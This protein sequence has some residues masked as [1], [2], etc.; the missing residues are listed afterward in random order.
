MKDSE[1]P[2]VVSPT[3]EPMTSSIVGE[4]SQPYAGPDPETA[5]DTETDEFIDYETLPFNEIDAI[6][7]LME[8]VQI[9]SQSTN[10]PLPPIEESELS[11]P[12]CNNPFVQKYDIPNAIMK[13]LPIKENLNKPI[14]R[15]DIGR[16]SAEHN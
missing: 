9:S 3:P 14:F 4:N 2:E 7:N 16:D 6:S 13:L 15:F 10:L 1:C 8:D 5:P 11:K 12:T